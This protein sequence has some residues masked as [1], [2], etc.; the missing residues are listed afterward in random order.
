[1]SASYTHEIDYGMGKKKLGT[2]VIGILLCVALT[3]IPFYIVMHQ[4]LSARWLAIAAIYSCALLQ[5][6]V[7]VVCFL[8]L[9]AQTEQGRATLMS[10]VFSIVILLVIVLGSLWI[11]WN[12]NY[13]M[14]H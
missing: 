9:N 2:Y 10:F 5:F 12:L 11:M 7:Q 13:N 4:V 14:V 1:M 3:L 6:I 8:R